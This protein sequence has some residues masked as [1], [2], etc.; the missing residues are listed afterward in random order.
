MEWMYVTRVICVCDI[1]SKAES[2][3]RVM[4]AQL[5]NGQRLVGVRYPHV[6]IAVAE[7][8]AADELRLRH[9][10]VIDHFVTIS[11]KKPLLAPE[12]AYNW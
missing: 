3:L 1:D 7:R 8:A 10:L 4:R 12:H 9:Q 6:L 2:S 11:I 5:D